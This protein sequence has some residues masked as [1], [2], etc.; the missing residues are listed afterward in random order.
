MFG[1]SD[2]TAVLTQMRRYASEGRLEMAEVMAGEMTER[3]L[4]EKDRDLEKQD[5][6]VQGLRDYA[7]ILEIRGPE[8]AEK[9]KLSFGANK[10]LAKQRKVLAKM[11]KSEGNQAAAKTIREH[12]ADDEV[13]AGRVLALMGKSSKAMS[14]FAKA[15]KLR[16]NHLEACIEALSTEFLSK[17]NLKKSTKL[18]NALTSALHAAGSVNRNGAAFQLLPVS[19]RAADVPA[20]IERV[21]PWTVGSAGMP[22]PVQSKLLD[23]LN[24]LS[25]QVQRIESGEQAANA[26]LSA[27]VDKLNP[28]M[29]YHAFSGS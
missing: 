4:A 21:M 28:T 9:L 12:Q 19:Q 16:P 6:L 13:Q 11:H 27:A 5:L 26:A 7:N 25:V 2:P 17:G 18:S 3:M 15:N 10:E 29:D 14:R 22:T 20:L 8:K 23:K 24:D 1:M